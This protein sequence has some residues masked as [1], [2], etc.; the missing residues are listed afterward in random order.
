MN[1]KDILN[2][3]SAL[4]SDY[5]FHELFLSELYNLLTKELKGKEAKFF[6][7]LSSQLNN[8]RTF[9]RMVY[10]VDSNEII[11][12]MDGHYYSIHLNN[13]QSNVRFLVYIFDDSTPW[14]LC[15]FYERSGKR[16]T[17]YSQYTPV[18]KR[19]FEELGDDDNE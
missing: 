4:F 3:L 7:I 8:I 10:T 17:D 11:K 16:K 2:Q 12:G 18:L 14:F 9:G 5:V 15:A 19:R 1:T 13:S 6:N